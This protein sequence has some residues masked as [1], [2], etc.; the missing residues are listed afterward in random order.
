MSMPCGRPG[1]ISRDA[2]DAKPIAI[3]VQTIH[4]NHGANVA[5]SFGGNFSP[6]ARSL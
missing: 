6:A 5:H 2:W 3:E 1:S 4:A